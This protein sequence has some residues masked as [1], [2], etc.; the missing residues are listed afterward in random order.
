[1]WQYPILRT[2]QSTLHFT[3]W[4][5]WSIEHHLDFCGKHPATLQLL[6]EGCSCKYLPLSIAK[7]IHHVRYIPVVFQTSTSSFKR[8]IFCQPPMVSY[9]GL[10]NMWPSKHPLSSIRACHLPNVHVIRQSSL[11]S[12]KH[13][14]GFQISAWFSKL[15]SG[16]LNIRKH[17][18]NG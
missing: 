18:P 7:F 8:H 14:H 16:P 5:I 17:L 2:A 15:P 9:T 10:T 12:H 11:R 4:H 6:P 1:M 13:P 3:S